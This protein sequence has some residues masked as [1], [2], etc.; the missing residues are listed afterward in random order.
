MA[1]KKQEKHPEAPG[2]AAMGYF[3][4]FLAVVLM[5]LVLF[6]HFKFGTAG[7]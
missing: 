5:S 3:A 6:L 1:D 4:I 2:L 7:G